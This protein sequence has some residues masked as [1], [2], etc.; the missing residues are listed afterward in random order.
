[1]S[2]SPDVLLGEVPT[3]GRIPIYSWFGSLEKNHPHLVELPVHHGTSIV[4]GALKYEKPEFGLPSM[5]WQVRKATLRLTGTAGDTPL[6]AEN[7]MDTLAHRV[8]VIH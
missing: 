6:R 1:M 8:I 5:P 7:P 4:F 3:F 2:Q